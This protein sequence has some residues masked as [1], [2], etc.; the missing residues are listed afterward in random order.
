MRDWLESPMDEDGAPGY[1][2]WKAALIVLGT[3]ALSTGLVRAG[4]FWSSYVLDIVGPAWGYILLRGLFS[5]RQ[6]AM[7]S[8]R[9]TPGRTLLLV[10]GICAL[11]EIAQYL[12][13]YDARYD[14][15]DFLAYA[16]LTVPVYVLDR[17]T[18]RRRGTS[19]G[20]G[21]RHGSAAVRDT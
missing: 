17:S 9:L 2:W 15:Y 14:P 3:I 13:L 6:P 7:L 20:A 19:C 12:E 11:V 10:L 16:S 18:L 1:R 5:R 4:G 21:D 8:R